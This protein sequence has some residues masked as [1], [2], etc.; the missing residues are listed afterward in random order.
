VRRPGIVLAVPLLAAGAVAWAAFPIS[1]AGAG[2]RLALAAA[3]VCAAASVAR[4]ATVVASDRAGAGRRRAGSYSPATTQTLRRLGAVIESGPWA[5]GMMIAVLALEALHRSRP[6]HTALL[7]IVLLCYLLALHLAES[8]ARLT[9]LRPHLP[10]LVAGVCLAG[11]S[12]AAAMLPAAHAGA[13]W[14]SVV[15][16]VAAVVVAALALPV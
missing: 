4:T 9:V 10:L 5:Q 7:G 3:A 14:L 15:A 11:L 12:A 6:L 8:A 16:A 1:G 13:T 2:A